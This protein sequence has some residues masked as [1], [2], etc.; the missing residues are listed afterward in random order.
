MPRRSPTRATT[1]PIF[2]SPGGG[3]SSPLGNPQPGLFRLPNPGR[4]VGRHPHLPQPARPSLLRSP[5]PQPGRRDHRAPSARLPGSSCGARRVREGRP[6]LPS[7]PAV[8][9]LSPGA[10][11]VLRCGRAHAHTP[12]RPQ[13][14]RRDPLT[15]PEAE[16]R[17]AATPSSLNVPRLTDTLGHPIV[18]DGAP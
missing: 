11:P 15:L 17:P 9:Y 7:P 5:L 1:T 10:S 4:W 8:G 18:S 12:L 2:P 14:P 3:Y 6:Q 13:A 16:V